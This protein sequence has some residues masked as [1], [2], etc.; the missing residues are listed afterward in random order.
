M[1]RPIKNRTFILVWHSLWALIGA[2]LVAG[3]ILLRLALLRSSA[4]PSPD[5]VGGAY[6]LMGIGAL[7]ICI[8]GYFVWLTRTRPASKPLA[9]P[10]NGNDG[11][12]ANP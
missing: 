11:I 1:L 3:G 6:L 4:P 9:A 2:V 8:S 7:R 10:T 5:M 12:E